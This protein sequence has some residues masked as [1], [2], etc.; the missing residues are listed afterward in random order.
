MPLVSTV[1]QHLQSAAE[2]CAVVPNRVTF[3]YSY[4]VVKWS[5]CVYV[6][7]FVNNMHRYEYGYR[8]TNYDKMVLVLEDSTVL[9]HVYLETLHPAILKRVKFKL[10]EQDHNEIITF[11]SANQKCRLL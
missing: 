6:S 4:S 7:V 9:P 1:L 11:F 3:D 10:K 8:C 2:M 5:Y